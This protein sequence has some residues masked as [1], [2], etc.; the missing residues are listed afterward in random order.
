MKKILLILFLLINA[1]AQGQFDPVP[2]QFS[3]QA[4]VGMN[5]EKYIIGGL[6]NAFQYHHFEGAIT[7]IM[8]RYESCFFSVR[9]GY[10]IGTNIQ[11][12]PLVARAYK[13]VTSDK[14][15]YTI[16]ENYWLW[17]YGVRL[18][19]NIFFIQGDYLE[20]FQFTIGVVLQ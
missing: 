5:S 20:N 17:D 13:Y 12:M 14:N 11:V 18:R 4:R 10:S 6:D 9:L 1:Y 19:K 15:E 8:D 2:S 7:M 3:V 16:G